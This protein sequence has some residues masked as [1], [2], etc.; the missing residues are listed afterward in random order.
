[1]KKKMGAKFRKGEL[2]IEELKIDEMTKEFLKEL[3]MTPNNPLTISTAITE[4]N[5]KKNYK[6]WKE[7]TSTSPQGRHLSMFKTWLEAPEKIDNKY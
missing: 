6:N 1:M 5:V 4:R 3:Q 7:R 2:N